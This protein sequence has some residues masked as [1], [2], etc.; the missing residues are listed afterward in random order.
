MR[1]FNLLLHHGRT[2]RGRFLAVRSLFLPFHQAA[3]PKQAN[4]ATFVRQLRVAV[5][6]GNKVSKSAVTRNRLKR[7]IREVVRWLLAAKQI[8]PGYYLL[9][10][11]SP[12]TL[13]KNFAEIKEEIEFL[14]KRA[15]VLGPG[16][17]A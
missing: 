7:Q 10:S 2:I 17:K 3:L 8:L 15:G 13:R 12:A 16:A 5:V 6:V 11:A 9:I 14:L 1:D 4:S